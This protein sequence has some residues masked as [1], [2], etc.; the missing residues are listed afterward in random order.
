[1]TIPLDKNKLQSTKALC[2]NP[3]LH[4]TA[5]TSTVNC[6]DFSINFAKTRIR[7][8]TFLVAASAGNFIHYHK[9]FFNSS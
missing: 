6:Q 8:R 4:N 1:M 2:F 5:L 7:L 3:E 9:S